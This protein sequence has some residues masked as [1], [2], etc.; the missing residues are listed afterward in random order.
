MGKRFP[1]LGPNARVKSFT[2]G[3]KGG[4][5]VISRGTAGTR[6]GENQRG[7]EKGRFA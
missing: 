4:K 1:T 3:E 5:G 7:S 2:D 6:R